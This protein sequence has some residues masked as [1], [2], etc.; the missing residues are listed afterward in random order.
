MM[1]LPS[2]C[3]PPAP[4]WVNNTMEPSHYE[5]IE[6]TRIYPTPY[7][8]YYVTENGNIYSK[9]GC[10]RWMKRTLSQAGYLTI[11]LYINKRPRTFFIHNLVAQV[12][13]GEKPAG[14]QTN[15]RDGNKLNN[16]PSNL[17]YVT[18]QENMKHARAM[19]LDTLHIFRLTSKDAERALRLRQ[20]GIYLSRVAQIFRVSEDTI[21]RAIHRLLLTK[22]ERK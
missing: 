1:R 9:M 17:E 22:A 15:H 21:Q 13:I 20:K 6:G 19:G 16:H 7:P 4:H 3:A 10:G 11:I 14:L 18:Q 5:V 8:S 12:F 2:Q